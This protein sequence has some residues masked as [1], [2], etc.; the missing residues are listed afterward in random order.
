VLVVPVESQEVGKR[1]GLV[2]LGYSLEMG[3]AEVGRVNVE[4]DFECVLGDEQ[5]EYSVD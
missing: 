4:M 5:I 1:G 3:Y 2:S